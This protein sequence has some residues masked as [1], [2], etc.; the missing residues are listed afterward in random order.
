MN[1]A[2][3]YRYFKDKR[4]LALAV[5]R[6]NGMVTRDVIFATSFAEFSEP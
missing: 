1:K 2:T 4:D 3:V 6:H 5:I